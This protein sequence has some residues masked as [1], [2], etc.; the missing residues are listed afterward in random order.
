M[1]REFRSLAAMTFSEE[2]K[3]M[4]GLPGVSAEL[5]RNGHGG[6]YHFHSGHVADLVLALGQVI[7]TR[8]YRRKTCARSRRLRRFSSWRQLPHCRFRLK[9]CNGNGWFHDSS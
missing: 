6:R 5:R 3:T 4:T 2:C 1:I 8:R 7:V 9:E